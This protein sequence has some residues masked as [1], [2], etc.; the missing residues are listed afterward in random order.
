M[1]GLHFILDGKLVGD[2]GEAVAA[3]MFGL[4]LVP[5][6]G[7]GIDGHTSDGRTVQVKATGTGRGPVFRQVDI[8]QITSSSLTSILRT[9]KARSSSTVPST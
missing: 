6:G 7:T 9:L 4:K 3:E 2:I 5:G 1:P 8:G